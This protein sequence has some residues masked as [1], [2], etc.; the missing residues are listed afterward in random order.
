M[1]YLKPCVLLL[2][3][4]AG[5]RS[6]AAP[7][8]TEADIDARLFTEFVDTFGRTYATPAERAFR[9]RVFAGNRRR[10]AEFSRNDASAQFSAATRWADW[11]EAEFTQ[12]HGY[13]EHAL[14][15]QFPGKG[16]AIPQLSP[17]KAPEHG[18]LDYVA[19]GAT[20]AV[21]N[22]GKC[23][24]CW[25]HGTTAVLESRLKLD[26][27]TITSLSEQYLMDCETNRLC[28]GCCGGL[29]EDAMRWLAG[30]SA[31]AY[32]GAGIASEAEYPYTSASGQ[33]PTEGKCNRSAPLVA[34]VTGFG[35]LA[36]PVTSAAVLSGVTQYGVLS[37]SM[38]S[39]VLQFYSKG[40]ITNSSACEN[41]NHVVAIVGYGTTDDGVDFYKV[42]NSYG[43]SFGEDG[44]FR[45]S[46]DAADACG[47]QSCV[48]AA[49][50]VTKT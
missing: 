32:S 24:S 47:M 1:L 50:G 2:A 29:T 17:T 22:Q 46:L 9:A 28:S 10:A 41:S 31:T 38:D 4:A 7:M 42:R 36:K 35:V 43:M 18:G 13:A 20:V 15:C 40:V 5:A 30:D 33:D 6:S 26:T 45:I 16:G 48:V 21:K 14:P 39:K 27:G 34:K 11:T 44:Y 3:V 19:L 23:G 49:T 37:T 8:E 12:S 25:A